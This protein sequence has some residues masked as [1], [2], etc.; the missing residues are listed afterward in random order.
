MNFTMGVQMNQIF[1]IYLALLRAK[2]GFELFLIL[3][4]AKCFYSM[5]DT[6]RVFGSFGPL[7][8]NN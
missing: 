2:L 7:L 1:E 8:V 6:K 3:Y 4:L 5:R